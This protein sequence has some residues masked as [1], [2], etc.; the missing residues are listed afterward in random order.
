LEVLRIAHIPTDD[1]SS[2]GQ[3]L[4]LSQNFGELFQFYQKS[5]ITLVQ[6]YIMDP[7]SLTSDEK[8]R[9]S[10]EAGHLEKQILEM[11]VQADDPILNQITER[12]ALT[13]ELPDG[14]KFYL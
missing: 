12:L 1:L 8:E 9:L 10:S 5:P 11:K 2:K 4:F 13:V 7:K 6:Q 14:F 3:S